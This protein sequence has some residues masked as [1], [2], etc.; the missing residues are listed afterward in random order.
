MKL[1]F[2]NRDYSGILKT[3]AEELSKDYEISFVSTTK[4]ISNNITNRCYRVSEKDFSDTPDYLKIYEEA[5]IHGQKTAIILEN[6]KKEKYISDFIIANSCG[7]AMYVK[8]IF[9]NIPLICFFDDFYNADT[10]TSE[11]ERLQITYNKAYFM[12]DLAQC[13]LGIVTSNEQKEKIPECFRDKITVI[14]NL[15]AQSITKEMDKLKERIN[16]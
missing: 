14:N 3:L 2:L 1:L 11:N 7:C 16:K 13:D 9:K 4:E 12:P 10:K 6:L 15:T 8:E 5:I